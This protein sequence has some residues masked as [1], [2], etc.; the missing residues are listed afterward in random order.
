[1]FQVRRENA[2]HLMP[3]PTSRRHVTRKLLDRKLRL[4]AHNVS[5]PLSEEM[6]YDGVHSRDSTEDE[7]SDREQTS[8]KDACHLEHLCAE[9]VMLRHILEQTRAAHLFLPQ[10]K[11]QTVILGVQVEV[12][13]HEAVA[14]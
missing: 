4:Q 13:H 8:L 12:H 3:N 6:A 1:M 11:A 7:P 2:S 9:S 5:Q 14:Q 10:P